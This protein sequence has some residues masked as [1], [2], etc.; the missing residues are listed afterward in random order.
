MATR[1]TRRIHHG[2]D[3]AEANSIDGDQAAA[4]KGVWIDH[5]LNFCRLGLLLIFIVT[6]W[7]HPRVEGFRTPAGRVP[8]R[9]FRYLSWSTVSKLR[10]KYGNHAIRTAA[11]VIRDA[12]AL[13]VDGI[14]FDLKVIPSRR[15]AKRFARAARRGWGPDWQDHIEVK[16]WRGVKGWRTALL[17]MHRVGFTTTVIRYKANPADLPEYVD[18]YRP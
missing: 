6:H 15:Q 12:K 3:Y 17:R 14:E 5:D 7:A 18:M 4:A 11:Q 9:A 16:V 1:N 8:R 13:G 10:S 2:D